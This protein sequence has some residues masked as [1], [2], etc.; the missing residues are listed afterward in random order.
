VTY[1]LIVLPFV[2]AAHKALSLRGSY[3]STRRI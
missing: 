2:D 1:K 3:A